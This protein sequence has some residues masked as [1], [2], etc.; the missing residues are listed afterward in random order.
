[1]DTVRKPTA[2]ITQIQFSGND[3]FRFSTNEKI[4]IVGPNNSGKSQTLREI[5]SI[6]QTAKSDRRIVVK[7]L[8]LG[9]SGNSEDLKHFFQYY[10][11]YVNGNYRYKNWQVHEAHI[12][13]WATGYMP[14]N[15][16]QGFI[17]N[18]AAHERLSIC[19]QQPSVSPDQQKSSPQHI[20]YD[21][22]VLMEK[23]SSLFRKAFGHD[24]MFDFRGGSKLP[25]HVGQKPNI[26]GNI[27]RVSDNYVREVR[28]QPLLDKQGDGVKSYAG[29][30]FEAIVND[31]DI[32]LIDEP[33]AFLHPPQMR[34]LGETLASEVTGQL[35]VATHSSDIL[36]GFLEG[37]RGNL[38]ILRICRDGGVNRV[39]EANAETIK[40]LWE[41]PELR[42]SN[43]LDGIF[44]E[45][46]IICEDDSDCRLYNAIS[47][48]LSSSASELWL[49]TA[50]VPAGG[51]H[52]IRKIASALRKTGVPVKA[53]FD[54]DFLSEHSLV[55][56]TVE[57]FGGNWTE[58]APIWNRVDLAVRDGNKPKSIP[59]IKAEIFT[60]LQSCEENALPKGDI[61]ESMKQASPW[62]RV[63]KYGTR[64]IP[65]GDAQSHYSELENRLKQI[66]IYLVPVG[67][68]ENF[69]PAIGKHGPKFVSHLLANT[70]LNDNDLGDLRAFAEAVHKGP[71]S[72][73][74]VSISET[75]DGTDLVGT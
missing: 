14:H 64:G 67:E 61:I 21:D 68:A 34:R 47:D 22:E 53:I 59:N 19:E 69:Y 40:E 30:L 20:L 27:D 7:R 49:D 12:P 50:Y 38:R 9:K 63:K 43:A 71:H 58:I 57:A 42:Y 6:C 75:E 1:M 60:L 41:K 23:V 13:T 74:P 48:Y 4:I 33:E 35:F 73:P 24:L 11:D 56:S 15:L 29:I 26:D 25:I 28:S 36:R 39:F 17:K 5:I 31:L 16:W 44:H 10:G 70:P 18:I 55:Q 45:Q 54:L 51:K 66:G 65:K 52:G 62:Q 46:T 37:S 2:H 8:S 3:I 72:K 32:T